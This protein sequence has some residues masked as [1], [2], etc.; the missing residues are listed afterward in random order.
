MS[1][2]A[3][4][5]PRIYVACLASYNNGI[6][7]GQWID[8]DQDAED[9]YEEIQKMLKQSPMPGAEEW[10]IHDYEG[11]ED[12]QLSEYESIE[13]I[14]YLSE[15]ID[16]HGKA[17]A[18]YVS[19]QGLEYAQE[20]GFEDSYAGTYKSEQDFGYE[21]AKECLTIPESIEVYFDYEAYTRDL[22]LS[23]YYS[24]TDDEH[25]VHVFRHV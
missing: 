15:M 12:I 6:L 3:L 13:K 19:Y 23:D 18:A 24:I 21:I 9:I 16:K 25:N 4:V 8:A 14:A 22:F 10:A 7:H 11:F 1:V 2:T 20:D 17:F 5:T